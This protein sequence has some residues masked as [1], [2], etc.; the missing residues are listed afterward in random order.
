M[1][2]N[3]G[4]LDHGLGRVLISSHGALTDPKYGD[5][6]KVSGDAAVR[7]HLEQKAKKKTSDW[8][9]KS[10][11]QRKR[12]APADL[13]S[14]REYINRRSIPKRPNHREHGAAESIDFFSVKN[15]TKA[16]E[17]VRLTADSDKDDPVKINVDRAR[18]S[19][20]GV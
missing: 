10:A 6:R 13:H 3:P 11:R 12:N 4:T 7:R 19:L 14:G 18:R 8:R 15:E 2:Y 20:T 16:Q 5:P 9:L 1:E 17:F